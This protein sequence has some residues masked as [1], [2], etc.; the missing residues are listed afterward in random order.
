LPLGRRA[1]LAWLGRHR[2]MTM[3]YEVLPETERSMIHLA[4]SRIMLKRLAAS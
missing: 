1:R 4:M 3:D 2:R